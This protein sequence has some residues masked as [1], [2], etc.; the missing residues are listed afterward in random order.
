MKNEKLRMKNGGCRFAP[1]IEKVVRQKGGSPAF[2]IF[3][4]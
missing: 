4:F 1:S 3:H 2:L